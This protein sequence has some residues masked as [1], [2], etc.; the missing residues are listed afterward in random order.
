MKPI[1][2]KSRTIGFLPPLPSTCVRTFSSSG[3]LAASSSPVATTTDKAPVFS[4]EEHQ[5]PGSRA[6][7]REGGYGIELIRALADEVSHTPLPEGGNRV[8]LI[9]RLKSVA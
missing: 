3:A 6:L 5:A 8:T 9:K 2:F 1:P 4:P 7:L